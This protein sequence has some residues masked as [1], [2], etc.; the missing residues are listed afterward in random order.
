MPKRRRQCKTW[1]NRVAR[2]TASQA[3]RTGCCTWLSPKLM[4]PTYGTRRR[5]GPSLMCVIRGPCIRSGPLSVF[6]MD[7]FTGSLPSCN[8][9]WLGTMVLVRLSC[10]YDNPFFFRRTPVRRLL[11]RSDGRQYPGLILRSL[12]PNNATANIFLGPPDPS[13]NG[14]IVQM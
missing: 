5:V 1:A 6:V 4:S 9:S 10:F 2:P 13:D 8:T 14:F 11:S 3:T 7:T 12:L